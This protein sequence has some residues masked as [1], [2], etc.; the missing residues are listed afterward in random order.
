MKKILIGA[1]LLATP[2]CIRQAMA[3]VPL[4][5]YFIAGQ[6][7]PALQSIKKDT[8]PG[9]ITTKEHYAYPLTA[10]NKPAASHYLIEVEG[11]D[12][13]RRWVAVTCG[14]YVIPVDGSVS[15]GPVVFQPDTGGGR[16]TQKAEYVLAISWQPAFCEGKPDKPECKTQTANRFDTD[17]FTLHGLWPQPLTNIFCHV[18]PELVSADKNGDWDKLPEPNLDET[19]RK[20]LEEVMPGMM[21]HLERHEWIKHGTCFNGETA[22]TYFSRALTLAN[23]LNTS[24]VRGLFASHIGSEITI[25]QIKDAFDDSFGDG[26][27]DRVRVACK[28]DGTRNLIG[29]LTIGLVGEIDENASLANLIAASSPT[30]PGCPRGIVDPVGFQ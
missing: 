10:K 9:S 20:S 3:D 17:H 26:A 5:G 14:E 21:S 12:P 23:Q 7:C 2:L 30:D 11:A 6:A 18:S 1:L 13:L 22:D 28:R 25:Q 16:P 19:T 27:G 29:E 15:P 4:S 8:N 24:K